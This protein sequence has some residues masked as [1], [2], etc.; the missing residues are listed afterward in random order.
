[1]KVPH[2]IPY[3]GSKRNLASRILAYFPKHIDTLIE[4]F[5]GSGAITLA[6]ASWGLAERFRLNDLNGPLME[7][8]RMIVEEPHKLAKQYEIVWRAQHGDRREYYDK[9]RDEFNRTRRPHHFLYL[10]ARC[11]KAAVRYNAN[12]E[13]NQSPDNRR[14]GALP[15]T[16]REHIL[17]A[18]YLLKGKTDCS[19]MDFKGVVAS[20]TIEDLIYMD[21]P[22]QGVCGERD[23]RYLKGVPFHEFV[24]ALETM[25]ARDISY[26]VSYDGRTGQKVH[27]RPLPSDLGLCRIELEASRSSQE[28]LLG[29]AA[30]THESLYLSPALTGRLRLTRKRSKRQQLALLEAAR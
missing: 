11:V 6:A 8:W 1:V 4:P 12:G 14:M 7:L 19:S 23:P 9:I 10:L 3:Q 30:I 25:I 27:G 22:Y 20:A 21:P 2:P 5:A 16:M 15:E 28:T 13:F 29:R 17:G 26:L 24:E 18:A